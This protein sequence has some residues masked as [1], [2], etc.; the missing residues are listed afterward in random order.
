MI[1][2][3]KIGRNCRRMQD[4][5]TIIPSF[6]IDR[7]KWDRC[8]N[9][10]NNGLIYAASAW[11]NELADHWSGI[12]LND[13]EMVM[14]VPWR[15]KFGVRYNYDVPFIQ[16]L[17]IFCGKKNPDEKLFKKALFSLCRYGEYPFNFSNS[18]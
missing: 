11:L 12:V 5:I 18:I 8:L 9:E 15:K 10:S 7:V 16:Q 14:P 4:E 2:Q 3:W 1:Y 13:Y 17:G 6:N